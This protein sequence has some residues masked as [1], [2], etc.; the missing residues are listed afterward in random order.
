VV[1]QGRGTAMDRRKDPPFARTGGRMAD[2]GPVRLT[3][4]WELMAERF[5]RAYV[6]SFARDHVMSELDGRTVAQAL[7]AGVGAKEIW[8]AVVRATAP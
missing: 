7:A 3:M 6:D 1:P 5:G 4:F 2:N 8:V